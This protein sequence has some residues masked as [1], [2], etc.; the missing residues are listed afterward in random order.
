M[1]DIKKVVAAYKEKY[2]RTRRDLHRIP[3]PAYTEEKT[4]AYVTE[5][6]KKEGLPIKTG[7]A[8]YGV[9]GLLETGKP[10]KTLMLRSDIDAL[11]IRE[12]TG[13]SFAST[14]E[15]AM[16]A[17]GHDGHMSM[18]LGAATVL[19]QIKD[20]LS[21]TIKFIFQPAEE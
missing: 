6:L 10:G 2:V 14:H 13:L 8:E 4:S 9:V 1:D 17:C 12:E 21:G 20:R 16:H 3:E 11:P 19:N 15:G 18:V 5:Y 7:I